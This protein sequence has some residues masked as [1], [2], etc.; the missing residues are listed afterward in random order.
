M[1]IDPLVVLNVLTFF[2]ILGGPVL[3]IEVSRRV[4]VKR[5]NRRRKVDLFRTLFK[6]RKE[7][8]SYDHVSALNLIELE[9]FG[10]KTVID[11]YRAYVNH[12]GQ[13]VPPP[14]KDEH[15]FSERNDRFHELLKI[16]A[17]SLSFEFDK[18]DLDRFGYSPIGWG[19]DQ[20]LGRQNAESLRDLL[21]GRRGL[22]IF[23]FTHSA[24]STFPP[25]PKADD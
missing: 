20:E 19:R 15:F 13:V 14:G 6:T 25:P 4:D 18:S 7:R 11:A 12:L 23:T 21:A 1:S 24:A 5:E 16:I 17:S 8:L 22:P 9:F 3:A 10:D 2:A